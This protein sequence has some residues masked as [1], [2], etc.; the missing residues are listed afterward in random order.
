MGFLLLVL[1]TRSGLITWVGFPSLR[2]SDNNVFQVQALDPIRS[3]CSFAVVLN[4][5][6]RKLFVW[7]RTRLIGFHVVRVVAGGGGRT[8]RA[9]GRSWFVCDDDDDDEVGWMTETD[10]LI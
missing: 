4:R 7:W 10:D 5:A 8:F 9:A 2:S 3:V 1:L 6:A